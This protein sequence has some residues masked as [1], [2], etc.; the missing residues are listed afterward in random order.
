MREPTSSDF[1]IQVGEAG[2]TVRFKPTDSIF[3]YYLLADPDDIRRHGPISPQ[4]KRHG[5]TGDTGDYSEEEVEALAFR[6]AQEAA[7]RRKT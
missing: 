2:I 3:S 6:L 4:S 7:E 5:N 1:D